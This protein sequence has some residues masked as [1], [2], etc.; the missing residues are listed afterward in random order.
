VRLRSLSPHPCSPPER[1]SG[2]QTDQDLVRG[3]GPDRPENY[4]RAAKGAQGNPP[5]QLADR[6]Y[7]SDYLFSAICSAEGKGAEVVVPWPDN[8]AMQLQLDEN[9]LY[10]DRN[11]HAV[12]L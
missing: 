8:Y 10:V 7:S 1:V 11:D 2:A 5:L 4:P 6:R 3:R 9:S 12:L